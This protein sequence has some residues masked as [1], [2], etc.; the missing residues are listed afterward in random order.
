MSN[1]KVLD[2]NKYIKVNFMKEET[3]KVTLMY[4]S[5]LLISNL[6]IRLIRFR[7]YDNL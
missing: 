4:F 6:K 5:K 3:R 7:L 2:T 1:S